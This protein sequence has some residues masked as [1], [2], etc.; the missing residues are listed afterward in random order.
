MISLLLTLGVVAG[1]GVLAPMIAS[2]S[3]SSAYGSKMEEYIVS[4]NPQDTADVE[5][6]AL[7]FDRKAKEGFL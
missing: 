4:N 2:N 5:R 7:E 6:L 1:A 3:N